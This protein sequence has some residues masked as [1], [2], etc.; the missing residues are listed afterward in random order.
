MNT[1]VEF[2]YIDS[3]TSRLFRIYFIFINVE[4]IFLASLTFFFKKIII[5][6]SSLF[7]F[8]T[9][10]KSFGCCWRSYCFNQW[11]RYDRLSPFWSCTDV[12]RNSDWIWIYHCTCRAEK[13]LRYDVVKMGCVSGTYLFLNN[14]RKIYS[15][16][17]Y[18]VQ[19]FM[20]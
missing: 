5:K 19:Y 13:M 7:I 11:K 4:L 14:N 1:V 17:L 9:K 12:E 10:V 8:W 15:C 2:C 16:N 3:N 20:F 6:F 18:I